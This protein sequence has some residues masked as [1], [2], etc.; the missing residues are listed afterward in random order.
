MMKMIIWLGE[1]ITTADLQDKMIDKFGGA[2]Y[3]EKEK[4]KRQHGKNGVYRISF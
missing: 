1:Y 2:C 3:N 4:S